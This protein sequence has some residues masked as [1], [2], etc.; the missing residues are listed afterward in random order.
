MGTPGLELLRNVLELDVEFID[1]G[2]SG[3]GGTYGLARD[4]FWT[5]LRAGRGLLRRLRDGDIE[6]GATECGACRIQMEQGVD[7]ANA[8]SDQAPQPGLWLLT[9]TPPA[10]QRPQAAPRHVVT[11]QSVHRRGQNGAA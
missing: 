8:S 7:Q 5:S 1:R 2:C 4:R 3:M 11:L 6:I 10:L 9:L